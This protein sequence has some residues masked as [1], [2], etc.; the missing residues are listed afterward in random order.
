[1]VQ[2]ASK[3]YIKHIA[4]RRRGTSL[5]PQPL[6]FRRKNTIQKH[7]SNHGSNPASK[8]NP[9]ASTVAEGDV[10]TAPPSPRPAAGE[11]AEAAAHA[12]REAERAQLAK[13]VAELKK[14]IVALEGMLA[15]IDGV[16]ATRRTQPLA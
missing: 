3:P 6:Y 9:A 2:A 8:G 12:R 10:G 15:E 5:V 14:E 4:D 1:M 13:E 11:A 16:D 7:M